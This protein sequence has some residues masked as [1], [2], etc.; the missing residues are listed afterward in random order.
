MSKKETPSENLP[1]PVAEGAEAPFLLY[2][3]DDGKVHVNVLIHAETLW[4]PLARIAELFDVQVPGI[5]KHLKNIFDTG[6]L[7][8]EATVSK[9]E[10]V[11]TEGGRSVRRN[12]D[13]YNL[14][15]IVAVGYRVNSKRATQFRIWATQILKEY[16]KKGF[17]LDDERLKHGKRVLGED[18]FQELLERVRSIRAS[19]RRI[20]Q[21]I[22]DIFA[23][24]SV[25][26]DPRSDITQNFYA[27]VHNKFH[28]AITGQTAA[29]IIHSKSDHNAPYAGL[30]TWKNAPHG[31][32]LASDV[33]VANFNYF[34]G[35][36]DPSWIVEP[37]ELLFAWAGVKG[38][39][40]GPTVWNGPRGL[41]NQHI[42]RIRPRHEIDL[43]WL[44]YA[45]AEVTSEIEAKA[46]GFKTNLVH[47]RKSDITGAKVVQPPIA[48]QREVASLLSCW[49]AA[50]DETQRLIAAKEKRLGI[51]T[52]KLYA[53]GDR[54]G[55]VARFGDFLTESSV[56][57]ASGRHAK[58]LSIKLYGKGVTA[59]D[60]KRA[61]SE[62]TQ[63]F[64]RR[65]GQLVYSK[66]D[67][68]NGAFGIV[69]PELD[70]YEST[71]DLPAFDIAPSVDP[72]WLLGY[73]T[74]PEYYSRQIGLAR[75]QR[76]AQRIHP[77]DFL[78]S[79]LYL[80]H[81]D[82]QQKIAS[83]QESFR[84]DLATTKRLLDAYKAQKS[85]LMQKLLTGQWRVRT[86]RDEVPA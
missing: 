2:A 24:C 65:V 74:R 68:L 3:G 55:I 48:T 46:H 83:A 42:Y 67:F 79:S 73:L 70:G 17:V 81:F 14:D 51:L 26:Y 66:L 84:H 33:T 82:L 44:H 53:R 5:S 4:L 64:V 63:Y 20:Y 34:S 43:H 49:D 10:I 86:E 1:I 29:E 6:E 12:I 22:T 19:E 13:Y 54:A 71:L 36:P 52:T 80:P 8:R 25:D 75:G 37:G 7:S 28:Y 76:K 72:A 9:M 85:G 62:Q 38:V 69:P 15:A 47:V 59:R 39:S 60:E 77:K 45:L 18:Y 57:G 21:Q 50:I 40:F 78:A 30:L 58:K 31:R 11:Q 35:E 16:I 41:L 56:A 61:G 32:I 23:E 27:M